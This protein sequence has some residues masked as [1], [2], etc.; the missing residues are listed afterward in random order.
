M[1]DVK[2]QNSLEELGPPGATHRVMTVSTAPASVRTARTAAQQALAELGVTPGSALV[3]AALLAISELVANAVRHAASSSPTVDIHLALDG[4]DLVV[5]VADGDPHAPSTD[6]AEAGR[7]L[8]AVIEVADL[9]DGC[10]C[11]APGRDAGK[12]IFVRF[13]LG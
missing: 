6:R 3:D 2:Q 13:R 7:G 5:G 11:V 10:V 4:K 9:Y 1:R 12:V 8:R